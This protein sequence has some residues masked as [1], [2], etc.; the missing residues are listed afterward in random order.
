MPSVLRH[1]PSFLA[2]GVLLFLVSVQIACAMAGF[3]GSGGLLGLLE[4]PGVLLGW[5]GVVLLLPLLLWLLLDWWGYSPSGFALKS[6]GSVALG[7]AVGG[8][9]G[10]VGGRSAG[11]LVGADLAALLGDALSPAFAIFALLLMAVPAGILAFGRL[12]VGQLRS[13]R[14]GDAAQATARPPRRPAKEPGPKRAAPA[15]GAGPRSGA[16][17]WLTGVGAL[18]PRRRRKA[19]TDLEALARKNVGGRVRYPQPVFDADGNELPMHFDGSRDVGAIRYAGEEDPP[20]R[21]ASARREAAPTGSPPHHGLPT[22]R[23]VLAGDAEVEDD[24]EEAPFP[25]DDE[26]EAPLPGVGAATD[27]GAATLPVAETVYDDVPSVFEEADDGPIHVDAHGNP[28]VRPRPRAVPRPPA[29]AAPAAAAP[30][31]AP[32]SRRVPVRADTRASRD[33]DAEGD[34]VHLPE[35]GPPA[36]VQV[37]RDRT[38]NAHEDLPADVRYADPQ[39][40]AAPGGRAPAPVASAGAPEP[41]LEA[42]RGASTHRLALQRAGERD[43]ETRAEQMRS[44]RASVLKTLGPMGDATACEAHLRK[45]EACGLFEP[46]PTSS[47]AAARAQAA[48]DPE[49]LSE[50]ARL[51]AARLAAQKALVHQLREERT[52]PLFAVAVEAAL[53]RGA[54]SLVLLSRRLGTSYARSRELLDRLL[55]TDVVGPAGSNGSH[56]TVLTQALW[57]EVRS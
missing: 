45:L 29:A 26:G 38:N 7:I 51:E 25:G 57:D 10:V 4:V 53:E 55:A 27:Q 36:S 12:G 37:A 21:A 20:A 41:V 6:L 13:V 48:A 30:S 35:D 32:V 3:E 33:D 28:V 31:P 14:E 46:A 47:P 18:I 49:G 23:D 17:A 16:S 43:P 19:S 52:D 11:G 40:T 56:P 34:V 50:A 44:V 42:L 24:L 8:L 5:G 39:P 2:P 15:E 22:L 9:A 1:L 54:V